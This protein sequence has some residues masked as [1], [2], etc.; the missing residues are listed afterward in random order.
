[1]K[2]FIYTWERNLKCKA[3]ICKQLKLYIFS[4]ELLLSGALTCH[5]IDYSEPFLILVI[6]F[7]CVRYT[8]P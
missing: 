4:A 7:L 1:M 8:T 3:G 5:S 6:P 2:G